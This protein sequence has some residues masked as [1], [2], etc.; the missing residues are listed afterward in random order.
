MSLPDNCSYDVAD[1][2]WTLFEHYNEEVENHVRRRMGLDS[3]EAVQ[4][5]QKFVELYLQA[6][7]IHKLEKE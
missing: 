6:E 2:V 5:A 7:A 3:V 1:K 4:A